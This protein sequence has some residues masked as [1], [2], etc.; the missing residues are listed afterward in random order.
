MQVLGDLV[1][2]PSDASSLPL[3]WWQ[4]APLGFLHGTSVYVGLVQSNRPVGDIVV[5]VLD[6]NKWDDLLRLECTHDDGKGVIAS[7]ME[8]VFPLNI[9]LAETVTTETGKQH[10]ATL[11]CE[12][13]G[14]QRVKDAIPRIKETLK[15]TGF[16]E[17]KVEPYLSPNQPPI[18]KSTQA[19]V[20]NGWLRDVPFAAW[21]Q[22]HCSDAQRQKIDLSRAVVSADTENRI[23]RYVFPYKGARTIKIIHVDKPGALKQVFS[24]F[25]ACDLNVLSALLRRGGQKPG[26]AE[27]IAVCEP[28]SD[29]DPLVAYQKLKDRIGGAGIDQKFNTALE[30]SEGQ[31]AK[32]VLYLLP[33]PQGRRPIFVDIHD[34]GDGERGRRLLEQVRRV[35][36]KHRCRS[37]EIIPRPDTGYDRQDHVTSLVGRADG[38]ILLATGSAA[39]DRH[40]YWFNLLHQLGIL[41]AMAKPLLIVG[42]AGEMNRLTTWSKGERT[43]CA[44][45]V[46]GE[47]AF[48]DQHPSSLE[49]QLKNWLHQARLDE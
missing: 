18:I 15:A 36:D 3:P 34:A 23:L 19:T 1:R 45:L 5:S 25:A 37:L 30:E 16:R 14:A 33:R 8:A 12:D 42:G 22:Q 13:K 48:D 27:M 31:A 38:A 46:D 29:D 28:K 24:Q 49:T 39:G 40:D 7:L 26:Y 10:Q 41:R 47:A 6:I 32:R 43:V 21:I 11:F 44:Q 9:A 17:I 4:R 20:D 35:L 2:L